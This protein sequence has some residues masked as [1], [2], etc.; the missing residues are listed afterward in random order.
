MDLKSYHWTAVAAGPHGVKLLICTHRLDQSAM[1]AV[2]VDPAI[3]CPHLSRG[4][5]ITRW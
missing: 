1:T 2:V 5:A 4:A 3:G